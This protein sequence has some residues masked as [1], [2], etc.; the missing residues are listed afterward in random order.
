VVIVPYTTFVG[1][2]S[3][4]LIFTPHLS[5]LW[6]A[7]H[8]ACEEK[9]RT[10]FLRIKNDELIIQRNFKIKDTVY[11]PPK[12]DHAPWMLPQAS[13]VMKYYKN[14]NDMALFNDIEK[15]IRVN[16]DL[17]NDGYYSLLA[18][19]V[20]HTYLIEKSNYSPMIVLYATASRGKTRTGRVLTS[21]ARCGIH[22][23]T[24]NSANIFRLADRFVCTIFFDVV[25][26]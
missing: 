7:V 20:L 19:W 18:A 8:I 14:D 15:G 24:L 1:P 13:E 21:M 25:N 4:V 16:C 3:Y 2:V 22:L 26:I 10:V 17:P 23:E 12:R 9:G 6:G 11:I 5:N